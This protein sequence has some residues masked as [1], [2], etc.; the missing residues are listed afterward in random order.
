LEALM[1][2]ATTRDR[3]IGT[4]E[5]QSLLDEVDARDSVAFLEICKKR[6]EPE[7]KLYDADP[8]CKHEIVALWS[9]VKCK[10]CPGWFC[11]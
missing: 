10:H 1:K 4:W 6:Q 5:I 9:G 8:N 2:D 3:N 7:Q 11:Y